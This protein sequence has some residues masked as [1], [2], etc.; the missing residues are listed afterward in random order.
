MVDG[1]TSYRL[2]KVQPDCTD[3]YHHTHVS[4]GLN[5]CCSLQVLH[6]VAILSS[7]YVENGIFMPRTGDEKHRVVMFLLCQPGLEPR[8]IFR[9]WSKNITRA[10]G[11]STSTLL[12]ANFFVYKHL[13]AAQRDTTP[14]HA[15]SQAHLGP[16]YVSNASEDVEVFNYL[17]LSWSMA[18]RHIDL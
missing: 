6:T 7:T 4:E 15:V 17:C 2:V 14:L 18:I 10:L 11:S 3:I 12:F 5:I 9:L 13:Y 1:Y 8:D 16:Q